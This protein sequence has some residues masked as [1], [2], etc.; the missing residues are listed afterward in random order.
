MVCEVVY[1]N[2]LL[3]EAQLSSLFLTKL[4]TAR[5]FTDSKGTSDGCH[6]HL[7]QTLHVTSW[8]T[9]LGEP[10]RTT[11]DESQHS[12]IATMSFVVDLATLR[13]GLHVVQLFSTH[14]R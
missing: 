8:D 4:P 9:R 7:R 2:V 14:K 13:D 11:C 12:C 5:G 6:P 1:G 3:M 10:H